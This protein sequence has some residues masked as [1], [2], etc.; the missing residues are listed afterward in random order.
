MSRTLDRIDRRILDILTAEGRLSYAALA[1][2]VG[3]SKSPCQARVKRL[4]AEGII[5]GY[6]AVVDPAALGRRHV[7]F[8]EVTLD[9]T[10][11][12]ALRAFDEAARKVPEIEEC[13]LIAGGFDYLLK[14]RTEDIQS[15]R[16]VLGEVISAL[17]H[18]AK[19]STHVAMDSVK[20]RWEES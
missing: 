13:H 20:D 12:P 11:E 14:V 10:R 4:E 1:E 6:R 17:P 5:R 18:V 9:D 2:R 8:A 19:T 7:A 15:Y 3:L 16:R